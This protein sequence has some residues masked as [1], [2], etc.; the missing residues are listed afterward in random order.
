MKKCVYPGSLDPITNGH[1]D[2]I[3]RASKIFDEVIV[4]IGNNITKK[5]LFTTLE[6]IE[7]IKMVTKDYPN[8]KVESFSGLIVD[9]CKDNNI[10]VI[11]RGIRN[12]SDYEGEYDLY[13]HNYD[14]NPN[15]ETLLMMPK[16][17]NISISSSS[18][19]EFLK[20]N[21]DISKYVPFQ[22]VDTIIN[23]YN[24]QKN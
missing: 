16:P 8:I 13:Q 4:L 17:E 11:I 14:I 12:Y 6:K 15:I 23:K 10:N 18:I 5:G 9:Y 1:L 2:V 19:K 22:L 7:M 21:C 3:I 20:F 24:E